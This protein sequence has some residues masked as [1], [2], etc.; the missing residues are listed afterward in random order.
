MPTEQ[1]RRR[2]LDPQSGGRAPPAPRR[3]A[4]PKQ[5]ARREVLDLALPVDRRIRDHRDCLVEMVGEVRPR[6]ERRERSVVTERADRLIPGLRH[7]RGLLQVVGLEPE[8][9]ELPLAADRYV[10]D[11]VRRHADLPAPAR[12]HRLRGPAAD[13]ALAEAV[14]HQAAGAPGDDELLAHRLL[15]KEAPTAITPQRDP[16]SGAQRVGIGDVTLERHETALARKDVLVL[17]LD[18]PERPKTERVDAKDAG[19]PD[20]RQDRRGPLR[21]RTDRAAPPHVAALQLAAPPLPPAA[22]RR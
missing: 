19:V 6:G 2:E 3:W 11:L 8:R 13:D 10:L 16:F 17:G 22:D 18:V 5:H 9:R 15:I 20:A 21:E 1:D 4:R 14:E 12:V 7:V